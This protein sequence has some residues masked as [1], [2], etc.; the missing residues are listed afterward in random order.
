MAWP[1][2]CAQTSSDQEQISYLSFLGV[3][4]HQPP[5][6]SDSLLLLPLPSIKQAQ[7]SCLGRWSFETIVCHLLDLLPFRISP[8]PTPTSCLST[9]WPIM[10]RAEQTQTQLLYL[11]NVTRWSHCLKTLLTGHII[12]TLEAIWAKFRSW[13]MTKVK[14]AILGLIT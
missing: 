13:K 4:R 10:Q 6:D 5:F 7:L 3:S 14:A 8:F 2:S 1:D 9:Y 12:Y 11:W